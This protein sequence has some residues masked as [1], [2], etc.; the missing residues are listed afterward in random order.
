MMMLA[1]KLGRS[2]DVS[3]FP[4]EIART[5]AAAVKAFWSSEAKLFVSGAK[6]RYRWPPRRG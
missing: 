4:A 3:D 6:D 5:E 2:A 1:E